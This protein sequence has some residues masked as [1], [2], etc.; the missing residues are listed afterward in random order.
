[1]R[2][3]ISAITLVHDPQLKTES[4]KKPFVDTSL[5]LGCG[6][7]GIQCHTKGITLVNRDQRGRHGFHN[8]A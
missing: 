5:C 4:Q 6:V 7:C 8:T 1:M 2:E 3:N